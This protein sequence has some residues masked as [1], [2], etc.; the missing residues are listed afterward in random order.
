MATATA[1]IGAFGIFAG[2]ATAQT[3]KPSYYDEL[4]GNLD[5]ANSFETVRHLADDIGGRFSGTRQEDQAADWLKQQMDGFGY[6]T[7]IDQYHGSATTSSGVVRS[8][9]TKL[10]PGP[11]WIMRAAGNSRMT[12]YDNPVSGEVI[13]INNSGASAA[14]FPASTTGKIA[15][16]NNVTGAAR[17]TAVVNAVAAGAIG[18]INMGTGASPQGAFTLTAPAAIPVVSSAD[19]QSDTIKELLC[20][21][22]P[23]GSVFAPHAGGTV[24]PTQNGPWC[25]EQKKLTLTI[26]TETVTANAAATVDAPG[27]ST[28]AVITAEKQAVGDVFDTAPIVGM[29]GH[30]DST[31]GSPGA[32][33]DATGQGIWLEVARVMKNVP[34]DK[35]IRFGGF[36]GEEQGLTGSTAWGNDHLYVSSD[37]D[38]NPLTSNQ[39]ATPRTQSAEAKRYIGQWQM[40]MTGTTFAPAKLWALT[41]DGRPNRVTDEAF[42]AAQRSGI[43]TGPGGYFDQC[44]LSQSDH[45]PFHN[46]GIPAA[47]FI[48]LDYRK[49]PSGLCATG[50]GSNCTGCSYNIEPVYHTARD[51]MDNVSQ[52][53][54]QE[55]LD[56][57]GASYIW[58]ALN[59]VDVNVTN[60]SGQPSPGAR[61]L[62]DCG[63]GVRDFG[64]TDSAGYLEVRVPHATCDFKVANGTAT[65]LA[66]DVA[67][68]GDRALAVSMTSADGTVA[69]SVPASLSLSLGTPAPFQPFVPGVGATYEASALANVTSSAGEAVLSV[70]DPSTDHTGHLVNG[71]FFLP[72]P[73]QARARNAA[74]TGTAYKTIGSSASPLNLLAYSGPVSN[75]TVTLG[76]SQ[77][78]NS[79]DALRTGAYSKTLT[80]TLSTTNP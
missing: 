56:V 78:I 25:A 32:H 7:K 74:N 72:Q 57:I 40:D 9:D 70:A 2:P 35:E 1:A 73:L 47:L 4:V 18:V 59:K 52:V 12:G 29:G 37:H 65:G 8:P 50:T 55:Q 15:A 28:R 42:K 24:G 3:P 39:V 60:G 10:Y 51:A 79:N 62:A 64:A 34:L 31:F 16:I 30:I 45:V 66:D 33:D 54:L 67:V 20:A 5:A 75:D 21:P 44:K 46:A 17:D 48:H 68:T 61:V 43:T 23:D 19:V 63:D 26:A 58:N 76:F 6:Q 53:Y 13:W 77:L 11:T 71:A 41:V 38:N 36:G 49:A 22:G 69:G 27:L 80:F 14:D